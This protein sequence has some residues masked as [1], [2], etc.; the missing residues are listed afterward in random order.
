MKYGEIT[1]GPLEEILLRAVLS[2]CSGVEIKLRAEERLGRT[3][4]KDAL[5]QVLRRLQSKG[6]VCHNGIHPRNYWATENGKAALMQIDAA[7]G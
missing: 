1:L 3:I 4:Q 2:P 5:Y 7:R 6:Y